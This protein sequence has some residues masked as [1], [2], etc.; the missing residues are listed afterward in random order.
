MTARWKNKQPS[1]G[2]CCVASVIVVAVTASPVTAQTTSDWARTPA[3]SMIEVEA[4]R[5][6]AYLTQ[7]TRAAEASPVDP[8]ARSLAS[9]GTE[10]CRRHLFAEGADTLA[11]ALR[12]IGQAPEEATAKPLE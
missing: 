5:C 1:I 9:R 10:L 3:P 7:F 8:S 12:Q 6:S 11:Q 2:F 4:G